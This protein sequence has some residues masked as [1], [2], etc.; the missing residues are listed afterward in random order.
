MKKALS[1]PLKDVRFHNPRLSGVGVEVM[2]LGE[3]RQRAGHALGAA[4]R[5]DFHLLL[6]VQSGH[7]S[8]MVDFVEFGLRPGTVLLVRPGQVHQWRMTSALQGHLMLFKAEALVP[9]I[10]QPQPDMRLLALDEWPTASQPSR[11]L[12]AAAAAD[13]GR[14]AG[15]IAGFAGRD[16]ESAI[17][18]HG[19]MALLLRL[20]CERVR[21]AGDRALPREAGMYRLFVRELEANFHKRLSVL[22]YARRLGYSE[23]TLSRAC[24]AAAGHT[25]KQALDLRIALEAKRLLVHSDETVVQIGHRL[26]FSEPTNFVKFFK[27]LAGVTPLEF[28][29]AAH[30]RP[31]P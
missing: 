1:G 22:D 17:I 7:A 24:L 31:A 12:F 23:S 19:L 14:L 9:S 30:L 29:A 6:L 2:T 4:E 11:S 27:R 10:A 20:A 8:H 18:R 16:I 5:V 28:R 21:Q 15:D 26:G 25:A 3:L 13:A